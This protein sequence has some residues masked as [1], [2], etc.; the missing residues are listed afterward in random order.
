[1]G[2]LTLPRL[3]KLGRDLTHTLQPYMMTYRDERAE[4]P[5]ER[6]RVLHCATPPPDYRRRFTS[7]DIYTAVLEHGIHGDRRLP[8]PAEHPPR[9]RCATCVLT[10]AV[11]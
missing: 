11:Q 8:P 4:P 3:F 2:E 6:P 5:A 9:K 10:C 1:M 7:R